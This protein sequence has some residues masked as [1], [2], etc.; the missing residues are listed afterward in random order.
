MNSKNGFL[1]ETK[2]LD[3]IKKVGILGNVCTSAGSN[4]NAPDADFKIK[5]E[6]YN[7]EIKLNDKAQ[8]GGSS[9]A[10]DFFT[11]IFNFVKTPDEDTSQ[12][13][14]DVISSKQTELDKLIEFI[15]ANEKNISVPRKLPLICTKQTWQHAQQ[16][17]LL[18]NIKIPCSIE[19]LK[20]HLHNKNI[21]Y[22]QIGGKGLYHLGQNP[23]NLPIE[24][25]NGNFCAEIRTARSGSKLTSQGLRTVT[26]AIR[27]Q[28]RLS[29]L[30]SKSKY[31]MDDPESIK[32]LLCDL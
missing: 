15:E 4:A 17:G 11:K 8:M 25:L 18:V 31:T 9:I 29:V 6:V 3:A 14:I 13:L 20:K 23:A 32:E 5:D 28:G 21:F 1:Y 10:Y 24:E 16:A 22:I 26:G 7:L 12:I 30:N 2:V 19:F 27:V